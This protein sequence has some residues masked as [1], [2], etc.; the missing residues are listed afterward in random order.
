MKN[1]CN[2]EK[3]HR[4]KLRKENNRN[5]RIDESFIYAYTSTQR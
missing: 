1:A 3:K 4:S 5:R 2:P